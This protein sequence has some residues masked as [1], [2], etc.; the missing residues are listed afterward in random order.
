[1]PAGQDRQSGGI[2]LVDQY[3][4]RLASTLILLNMYVD[5]STQP[6]S[7]GDELLARLETGV[8]PPRCIVICVGA[9]SVA[10][11][12]MPE[13]I[14]R[15]RRALPGVPIIIMSDREEQDEVLATFR[16]GARAYIPTSLDPHLVVRAIRIVLAGG[17]FVPAA[18]L[19]HWQKTLPGPR[20]P[21]DPEQSSGGNS[22]PW[23]SRQRAVLQLLAHGKAN[24]EIAIA[25]RMEES[26][27]KSHVGIIIRRLG[28]TNRTQAALYAR[29]LDGPATP[30]QSVT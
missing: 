12:P 1:M 5:G 8:A 19:L 25:L 29:R 4:L 28:V 22:G 18:A 30:I 13:Q 23:P 27:V 14:G 9:H 20:Q 11:S 16:E 10:Q 15:I 7:S 21:P 17:T 26:T 3:P 24:R 6:F 2:A